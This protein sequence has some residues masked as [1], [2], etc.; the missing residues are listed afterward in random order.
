MFFSLVSNVF[1]P[2]NRTMNWLIV[3][4][5]IH[6]TKDL[7][8]ILS[9]CD[10]EAE[11]N[12]IDRKTDTIDSV[13]ERIGRAT[14]CIILLSERQQCT[15]EISFLA[16]YFSGKKIPVYTT[17]EYLSAGNKIGAEITYFKTPELLEKY[18]IVNYRKIVRMQI[19]K[20]SHE[21]LFNNGIPFTSASFASFIAKGKLDICK[22]YF[23]AG[24]DLNIRDG[25]GTPVLNIATRSEQTDCI[26]WLLKNGADI[27]AVS[28]DRGYTALMDAVW[29]GNE[30]I[31]QLLINKGSKMNTVNKEGQTMLILAVGA[32][33]EKICRMLVE[34]GENPDVKDSMGMSAYEYAKL[35]KKNGIVELLEKYRK[36]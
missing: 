8:V 17:L 32:G 18:I 35:F 31:A 2:Y 12:I 23:E 29:R 3:A 33:R 21:Y 25:E 1:L 30:E 4:D 36:K 16:G 20:Q 26:I 7:K 5:D 13:S 9:G 15:P 28:E 34:H 6:K 19:K 11:T 14:H 22:K 10:P 27:N 24:M